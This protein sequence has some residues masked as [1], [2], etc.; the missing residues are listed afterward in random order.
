LPSRKLP[1]AWSKRHLLKRAKTGKSGVESGT[2][3]PLKR[4]IQT[5]KILNRVH[6]VKDA[7]RRAK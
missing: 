4:A 7:T 5:D 3:M 1:L 2:L 6:F